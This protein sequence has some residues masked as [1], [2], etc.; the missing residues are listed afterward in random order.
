M[1]SPDL[2][3]G[4]IFHHSYYSFN[5]QGFEL[6]LFS[7]ISTFVFKKAHFFIEFEP[8]RRRTKGIWCS[9][10]LLLRPGQLFVLLQ[11]IL[12]QGLPLLLWH[13]CW[14]AD[15][16]CAAAAVSIVVVV[17]PNNHPGNSCEPQKELGS[18]NHFLS[19]VAWQLARHKVIFRPTF[20]REMEE[21]TPLPALLQSCYESRMTDLAKFKNW[22]FPVCDEVGRPGNWT[23]TTL[24]KDHSLVG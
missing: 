1:L 21:E 2:Q 22:S 9:R 14:Q 15:D 10:W 13:C 5:Q 24:C 20:T 3:H 19:L 4:T 12:C 23:T 8:Q 7:Y 11:L 6:V 16:N 18:W 17:V